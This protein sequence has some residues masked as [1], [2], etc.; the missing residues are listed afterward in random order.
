L[1]VSGELYGCGMNDV[2]QLGEDVYND[3]SVLENAKV[4]KMHTSDITVPT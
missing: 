2:G 1:T 4:G 3:I